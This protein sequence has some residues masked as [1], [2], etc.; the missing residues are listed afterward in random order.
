MNNCVYRGSNVDSSVR[1]LCVARV[2]YAGL[3]VLALLFWGAATPVF[4]DYALPP[5]ALLDINNGTAPNSASNVA[6]QFQNYSFSFTPTT[7]GNN[8][9]LFAFRQDPAF[10]TFGNTSITASGSTTNLFSNPNFTQGGP[11]TVNGSSITAPASWGVVYQTGT[12]PSSAG[13][14]YAAGSAPNPA[15]STSG[16]GVNYGSSG[17]WYD[18]AVGSFDGIY[19]GLSLI[20]GTTYTVSFTALS[21]NLANTSTTSGGGVELGAFAGPC[22][23]LSGSPQLCAPNNPSFVSLATPSQTATAGAPAA[24]DITAVSNAAGL[25]S[26]PPVI[27]PVFDGGTLVLDGTSLATET[28]TITG[29]NGTINLAGTSATISN[30]IAD[31]TIGT[32]GGLTITNSGSGGALTLSGVNTYTGATTVSSGAT[33]DLTGAGSIASSSGLAD[34]GTL[35]I[36]G[37]SGSESLTTLSGNGSVSL[38]NNTLK[39]TSASGTFS[40]AIGGN[41]GVALNSG[42]ETLSGVNTYA[43]GTSL[44]GGT[45]AIAH[46]G[47]LG[48]GNVRLGNGTLQF[49][50]NNL[51]LANNVAPQTGTTGT[52][53]VNGHTVTLTGNLAGPGTVN[54]LDSTNSGSGSLTLAGA[55]NTPGV[56]DVQNSVVNVGDGT[57]SS[58]LAPT[59]SL[60][61]SANGALNINPNATLQINPAVAMNISPNASIALM[62]GTLDAETNASLSAPLG[63][64]L[65]G[66]AIHVGSGD[67]LTLQQGD[68]GLGSINKTGS[69]ILELQGNSNMLGGTTVTAGTLHLTTGANLSGPTTVQNGGTLAADNGSMLSGDLTNNGAIAMGTNATLAVAGS[70]V[71]GPGGL[72]NVN[73]TPS[74]QGSTLQVSGPRITLGGTLDVTAAPGQYL[75]TS[76][77]LVNGAAGTTLSGAF[78]TVN[79]SGLP[80]NYGWDIGYAPNPQALFTVFPKSVFADNALTPNQQSVGNVLDSAIPGSTGALYNQLNTLFGLSPAAQAK[81]LDALNGELHVDTPA[82]VVAGVDHSW[83]QVFVHMDL[84]ASIDP[85][86]YTGVWMS[87]TNADLRINGNGNTDGMRQTSNDFLL[88]EQVLVRGWAAG[89][90]VGYTNLTATRLNIGNNSTAQLWDA[91]VYAGHDLGAAHLGMLLGYSQGTTAFTG[92]SSEAKIWSVQGRLA[93]TWKMGSSNAVT[94]LLILEGTHLTLG[95]VT[96]S[97]PVLGLN[98]PG[99]SANTADTRAMVR[100]DH[101]WMLGRTRWVGSAGVGVRQLLT[102]P[103]HSLSMS[104]NGI[105][106]VPFTVQGVAEDRTVAEFTAGLTTHINAS[107]RVELGYDGVYGP[108]TRGNSLTGKLAWAF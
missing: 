24:T 19:Q 38:G 91:G 93:R 1:S 14:W 22:L 94:P 33:L 74:G 52:L 53:D 29:N 30:P 102:Q 83:D 20:G 65:S 31:A 54:I 88:G 23:T 89:A 40:G 3:R 43:G 80:S 70:Y 107:M 37:A 86:T 96:A 25:V 69:G 61:V 35:D 106:G 13:Q 62:G 58:I 8:Y 92:G 45:L 98:V 101:D 60:T 105:P 48:S 90:V 6:N 27:L 9:V 59:A 99:Q 108:H 71:Q 103:E 18:G 79:V 63:S 95:G 104:F 66:G 82:A 12:V 2:L 49:S 57:H 10:W 67:T 76:Y 81:S 44:D 32:P 4:A 26:S 78:N 68:Y 72:L 75:K 15:Y 56:L 77:A 41:G 21:Q 36:S 17:S 64:T 42:T 11:I 34:N 84:S 16:L 85:P 51:S 55:N 39:L 50:A 7:T 28:F 73:V 5:G 47:A 97:D 87:D 46:N 100:F